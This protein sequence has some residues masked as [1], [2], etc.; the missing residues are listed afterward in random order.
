MMFCCFVTYYSSPVLISQ[1][2]CV[3]CSLSLGIFYS[4][5]PSSTHSIIQQKYIV[6][7][8]LLGGE[9]SGVNYSPL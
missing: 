9:Y 8:L 6:H 5:L 3:S 7:S 4:F 2:L 1:D